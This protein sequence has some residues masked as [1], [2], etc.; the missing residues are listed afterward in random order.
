MT[1]LKDAQK[2]PKKLNKFIK[3]R[4]KDTPCADKERFDT[5]LES[6]SKGKCSTSEK[7]SD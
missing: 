4:E 2:D 1:T 6:M 3:E 7:S 5:T